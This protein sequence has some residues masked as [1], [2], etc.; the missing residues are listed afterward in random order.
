MTIGVLGNFAFDAEPEL[1]LVRGLSGH[2]ILEAGF[3]V[4][5]FEGNAKVPKGG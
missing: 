4:A 1:Y 2:F 5:S 3:L